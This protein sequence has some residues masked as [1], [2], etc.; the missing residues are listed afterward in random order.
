MRFNQNGPRKEA[1]MLKAELAKL[2]IKL[3]IIDAE[4]GDDITTKARLSLSLL[5][6]N[7]DRY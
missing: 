4:P 2:A 7:S 6:R 5:T 3:H 1:E